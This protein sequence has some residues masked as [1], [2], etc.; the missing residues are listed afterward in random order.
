[1][2]GVLVAI[3]LETTGLDSSNDQIIEIGA[4]KFQDQQ[5]LDTYTTLIDPGNPIPAKVTALTGIRQEDVA[6]AP[7]IQRVLPALSEFVGASPLIGHNIEFDLRFLNQQGVFQDNPGLD[8]YE[9]ASVLLPT[10]PRYNLNALMQL[11]RL[12]P[13]GNYHRALADAF[14]AARLYMALWERLLHGLPLEVLREIVAMI[15]GLPWRAAPAFAAAFQ[16]REASAVIGGA[17]APIDLFATIF[18]PPPLRKPPTPQAPLQPVDQEGLIA[19][20]DHEMRDTTHEEPKQILRAVYDAFDTD[21]PLMIE[22]TSAVRSSLAWLLPAAAWALQNRE[23]V[24]VSVNSD[25]RQRQLLERALPGV[26][27]ALGSS[28]AVASLRD[29]GHYLCPSRLKTLRR[30]R[31]AGVDELRVVAKTLVWVLES[32]GDPDTRISLRGLAEFSAWSRLSAEDE[33]C[34]PERCATQMKGV[35]PFYHAWRAAESADLVIVDHAFLLADAA[36]RTTGDHHVL[37]SYN[38]VIL[39]EVYDLE[40][41]V[42][43]G[44]HQRLDSHL[45]K[46]RLTDLGTLQRGLLGDVVGSARMALP[47]EFSKKITRQV[48]VFADVLGKMNIHVDGLFQS[49]TTLAYAVNGSQQGDFNIQ[50]R[51]TDG[52][53]QREEFGPLRQAWRVLSEFTATLSEEISRF[54]RSLATLQGKYDMQ[55]LPDLLLEMEASA[56]HLADLHRQLQA[57]L[58]EPD[59]N[60]VYWLDVSRDGSRVTVHSAPLSVGPLLQQHLWDACKTVVMLSPTL[61]AGD[62]LDFLRARFHAETSRVGELFAGDYSDRRESTLILLPDDMPE[63]QDRDRYQKAVERAIIEVASLLE[64]RLLV[65]FTSFTQLRQ[66]AQNIAARLALGDIAV[67][68]QSDGTSTQAL[69]EGFL[70]VERS[71]LLGSRDFWDE[72]ALMDADLAGLIIVRLPFAVPSDPVFSSRS[73]KLRDAFSQYTLPDAILRF[74]QGFER[75]GPARSQRTVVVVLDRRVT[76]KD[77]GQVFLDSLPPCTVERA[78]LAELAASIKTWLARTPDAS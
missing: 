53:R 33:A 69:L 40:E 78:P 56:Q 43:Y 4:V 62:G 55:D 41:R 14:A 65:L 1:M 77:Y 74:R 51:L 12:E 73:E 57:S 23:R 64:G 9:L 31:P 24:V 44:L 61:R 5:I 76:S 16:E 49:L 3:D 28:I 25:S 35:C 21:S 59:S 17:T 10:A 50:V 71:V 63:P 46:Q 2:R 45:I 27:S 47:A 18:T 19:L 72:A 11:L 38:R 32:K 70:G 26:Q 7:T 6:G 75:L 8:T 30:R 39:D 20:L 58:A 52:L 29:R 67:F 68:D 60:T 37:P 66:S 22:A 15:Q 34:T 48:A 42:T 54:A 13:E 36:Q